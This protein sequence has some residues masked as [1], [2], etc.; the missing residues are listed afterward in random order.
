MDDQFGAVIL[1]RGENITGARVKAARLA[2]EV[3]AVDPVQLVVTLFVALPV[4]PDS[5][6]V[7][8][9][10]GVGDES[11]TQRGGASAG[12]DHRGEGREYAEQGYAR[13]RALCCEAPDACF[14]NVRDIGTSET[15]DSTRLAFVLTG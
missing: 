13:H 6:V 1:H 11:D 3:K 7:V 9:D 4:G 5:G 2:G 8:A 14:G 12:E 10:T 15:S